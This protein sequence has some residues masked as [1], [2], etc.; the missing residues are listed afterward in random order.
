MQV[1]SSGLNGFVALYS[2]GK[3]GRS[4]GPAGGIG[5]VKTTVGVSI[6]SPDAFDEP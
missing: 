2:D 1:I 4:Y 6:L 3:Y 5:T